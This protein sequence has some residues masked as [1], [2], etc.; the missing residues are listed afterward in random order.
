MYNY[1]EEALRGTQYSA[2]LKPYQRSKDGRAAHAAVIS[3]YAGKDKWQKQLK[4]CQD[5]MYTRQWKGQSNFTL[6]KFVTQHRNAFITMQACAQHVDFQLPNEHTRVNYLLDAID[7]SDPE[8][9]AT[10]AAI[11]SDKAPDGKMHNFEDTAA[12]LLPSDPVAKRRTSPKR[13]L[14]DIAATSGTDERDAK[15][16]KPGIG[17][18]GVD[19]RYH[20]PAEYKKLDKLQKQELFKWR[21]KKGRKNPKSNGGKGTGSLSESKIAAAVAKEMKKLKTVEEADERNEEELKSYILSVVNTAINSKPA[22]AAVEEPIPRK[23]GNLKAII[24]RANTKKGGRVSS[25]VASEKVPEVDQ[26]SNELEKLNVTDMKQ[27][28]DETPK[29]RKKNK[30]KATVLDLVEEENEFE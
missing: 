5:L 2:S 26:V 28:N 1:L 30:K 12:Y 8:L 25:V 29:K 17:I 23:T 15:R 10:M 20:S 21:Q 18:T 13:T 7:N 6:E 22:A 27:T 24:G 16:P 9:Q 4:S 14:A 11:K 19:L 3:Q